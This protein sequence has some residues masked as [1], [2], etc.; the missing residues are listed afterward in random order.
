MAVFG[1]QPLNPTP[2]QRAVKTRLQRRPFIYFGLPFIGLV[3]FS[4]YALEKFTK[5][6]Y[7]YQSTKVQS[8]TKEEQLKMDKNRKRVDLKEEYYRL[9]GLNSEKNVDDDWENVR[10]PR[11]AGVPEWGTNTTIN[12]DE[13]KALRSTPRTAT[14]SNLKAEERLV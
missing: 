8:V 4:S 10:V 13:L 11:P 3:I 14:S 2:F 12:A 5:T 9:Q 7:E 1:S 6:R